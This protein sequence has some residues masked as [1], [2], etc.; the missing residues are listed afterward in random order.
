[1]KKVLSLILCL[2]LI[3][4]A[5]SA[6]NGTT[7]DTPTPGTSDTADTADTSG[8]PSASG[9]ASD[10]TP[11]TP[12]GD[13]GLELISADR[14]T[15]YT[16]VRP[17]EASD[18]LTSAVSSMVKALRG[19]GVTIK[20]ET[21]W[22]RNEVRE[23]EIIIGETKRESADFFEVDRLALGSGGYIIKAVGGKLFIT[24]GNDDSTRAAVEYFTSIIP[25]E[26]S[27]SLP[28]DYMYSYSP[29][30]TLFDL[31]YGDRKL[32]DFTISVP[33]GDELCRRAA[34]TLRR[35][36]FAACGVMLGA[37]VENATGSGYIF[38]SSGTGSSISLL[39]RDGNI[40]I[41]GSERAGISR[42][43]RDIVEMA[44]TEGG[45]GMVLRDGDMFK[46]DYGTG[47]RYEDFG[48][49]GDG[50]TDDTE[51]LRA[52]HEYANANGLPVLARE[53][54]T[55]Y[56][57]GADCR[58]VIQTDVDW[59][60]A[61]FIIDDTDVAVVGREVFLVQ[62]ST[63]LIQLSDLKSVKAG[64]DKLD[65]T[66]PGSCLVT[67]VDT[68]TKQYIRY[69]SNQDSGAAQT[70]VII[71]SA[72]GKIDP[73]T[74]VLWDFNQ[75]TGAT[76]RLI[77]EPLSIRGGVFTTIANANSNKSYYYRGIRVYRSNVTFDGLIHYVKGE[78]SVGAPYY[79]ILIFNGSANS[80]IRNCVLSSHK[81]Y[82]SIGSAGKTVSNGSYDIT[83]TSCP[84]FTAENCYEMTDI[85][86]TRRWGVFAS[87][88]AKNITFINCRFSRFDAHRGV[89]GVTLRDC[90]FG[91]Q[92]INLIGHGT[93][94]IDNCRIY[95]KNVCNLRSDY[96]S[97]W[98]GDLII[99]NVEFIPLAA[100]SDVVLIGGSN[101]GSHDFGY[102]CYLPRNI[103]IDG[104]KIDDSKVSSGYK[105]PTIFGVFNSNHASAS[106]VAKYPIVLPE[107]ITVSGLTV[108][109]GKA[110]TV[111]PAKF[112]FNGISISEK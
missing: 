94:E 21:D 68:N 19:M 96:G 76:A 10:T 92:G 46:V 100:K 84:N 69:G 110:L 45:S 57:G 9:G 12:G 16:I 71:V 17:D 79:G 78:G 11:A 105:G 98:N 58:I 62:P 103:I 5:L 31:R 88:Y 23:H 53:D 67:L 66:L 35:Q 39:A 13:G 70:D 95:A 25:A 36:L 60:C 99:R 52:A 22:E 106:Y 47:V 89:S 80:V 1:M 59:S 87:N 81:T 93:A 48:A 2:L 51:A 74:P 3:A 14:T 82:T 40:Y 72:D 64:Q 104:L 37:P 109:S 41:K 50:K 77:D 55:Y 38:I 15:T 29:T 111:S 34:V 73:S 101:P 7:P 56:I 24:G 61:E 49:K 28:E 43:I 65:V 86:D 26:G 20:I 18:V 85:L 102:T 44:C 91:H 4:A 108:A 54:A 107:S 112:M 33:S 8:N 97:T 32:S 90:T 30:A 63:A 6:C 42:G 27:F 75:L 83:V